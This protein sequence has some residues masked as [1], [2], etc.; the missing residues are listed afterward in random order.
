MRATQATVF[1]HAASSAPVAAQRRSA[2]QPRCRQPPAPRRRN[3]RGRDRFEVVHYSRQVVADRSRDR[4]VVAP[5]FH[6][7]GAMTAA[8]NRR[9]MNTSP[10]R[11][12][13]NSSINA[14]VPAQPECPEKAPASRGAR[15]ETRR[16][17]CYR[18][19]YLIVDQDGNPP[20]RAEAAELIIALERNDRV[21][22]IG[23]PLEV[24]HRHHLAHIG[25]HWAA[26][27]RR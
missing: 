9:Q 20:Q 24:A 15:Q 3:R 2:R 17:P 4:V 1:G 8:L 6:T 11:V 16:S 5:C 18:P 23:C 26:D 25:R 22:A 10:V 14:L 27:D 13:A 7:L 12:S 21:D 19:G